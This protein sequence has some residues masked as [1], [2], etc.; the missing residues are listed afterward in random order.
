MMREMV[1][2]R[3]VRLMDALVVG[4]ERHKEGLAWAHRPRD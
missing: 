3:R 4:L 1:P 2:V